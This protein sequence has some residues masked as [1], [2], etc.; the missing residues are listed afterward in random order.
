MKSVAEEELQREL[1]HFLVL[2]DTCSVVR[3][4]ALERERQVAADT[5]LGLLCAAS[6]WEVLQALN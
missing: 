2:A 5:A 6:C 1:V 3:L 4:V